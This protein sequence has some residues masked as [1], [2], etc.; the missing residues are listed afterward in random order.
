MRTFIAETQGVLKMFPAG[1]GS[2]VSQDDG[3]ASRLGGENCALGGVGKTR[4]R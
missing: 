2:N 1:N 3:K 4:A